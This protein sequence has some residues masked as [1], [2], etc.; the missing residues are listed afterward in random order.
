[1][2]FE[3]FNKYREKIKKWSLLSL[4]NINYHKFTIGKQITLKISEYCYLFEKYTY[5]V[6]RQINNNYAARKVKNTTYV[7][8]LKSE[9]GFINHVKNYDSIIRP[10][11]EKTG[12]SCM[13]K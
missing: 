4:L 5:T 6:T 11:K 8:N 12:I 7:Q 13:I 3:M 1:M 2:I 10:M 9:N